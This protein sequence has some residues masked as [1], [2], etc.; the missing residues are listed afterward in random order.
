[1]ILQ[2]DFLRVPGAEVRRISWLM[3]GMNRVDRLQT[4]RGQPFVRSLRGLALILDICS[5]RGG[6]TKLCRSAN[7]L[8]GFQRGRALIFDIK[9]LFTNIPNSQAYPRYDFEFLPTA[10]VTLLSS[11]SA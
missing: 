3:G 6:I 8:V 1:M 11:C 10:A 5:I 7:V 4:D 9:K 2:L